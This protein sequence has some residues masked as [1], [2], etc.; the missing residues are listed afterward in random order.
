MYKT[1]LVENDLAYLRS[2]LDSFDEILCWSTDLEDCD[3][4]L[5]IDSTNAIEKE[6]IRRLH[7][8]NIACVALE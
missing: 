5:R 4:I 1:S 6:V 8:R 3:K 2:V 7:L